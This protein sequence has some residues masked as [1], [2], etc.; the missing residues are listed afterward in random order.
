MGI[1]ISK[2]N[3]AISGVH[4]RTA[5]HRTHHSATE[6]FPNFLKDNFIRQLKLKVGYEIG[7]ALRRQFPSFSRCFYTHHKES[8]GNPP[9][10]FILAHKPS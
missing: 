4:S 9:S 7:F 10:L 8:F 1:P 3:W 2:K 6:T 5:A